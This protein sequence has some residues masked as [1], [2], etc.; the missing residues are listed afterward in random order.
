MKKIGLFF[1]GIFI[2]GIVAVL[3]ITNYLG[4]IIVKGI[5]KVGPSLTQTTVNLDSVDLQLFKGSARIEGFVVG[6]PKG[7]KAV[8][9][10]NLKNVVVDI[11]PKTILEDTVVINR[12]VID[13]PVLTYEKLGKKANIDQ[14]LK[15]VNAS[16]ARQKKKGATGDEVAQT[17]KKGAGKKLIVDDFTI[18][19]ATLMVSILPGSTPVEIKLADIHL[20]GLGRKQQGLTPAE[21]VSEIITVMTGTVSRGI[22]QNIGKLGDVTKQ[23]KG[24]L[25]KAAEESL[26]TVDGL[27]SGNPDSSQPLKSLKGLFNAN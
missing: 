12:V 5:E 19:N 23:L 25:G 14:L 18:R 9:V 17:E 21:I 22:T 26:K 6:N 3:L 13:S 1:C 10:F 2:V 11:E 4:A 8:N 24:T 16:L 15:N 7:F 20:T 27:K